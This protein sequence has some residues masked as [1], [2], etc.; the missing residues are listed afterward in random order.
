[1]RKIK[2]KILALLLLTIILI[3][4][5]LPVAYAISD[6]LINVTEENITETQENVITDNFDVLLAGI[7]KSSE[8]VLT[9]ENTQ[10]I[11]SQKQI[12]GNGLWIEEES[13]DYLIALFNSVSNKNYIINSNG[14]LVVD[15]NN[16]KN[17][18]EVE[19]K[20]NFYT[21]KFDEMIN[22]E[23]C[24]IVS[25]EETYKNLNTYDNEILD[26]IIE[27]DEYALLFTDD[28][29]EVIVLNQINY[30]SENLTDSNFELVTSIL[31]TLYH[32]DSNFVSN[33]ETY[34]LNNTNAIQ[35]EEVENMNVINS[36]NISMS[37]NVN[38]VEDNTFET[39]LSDFT[40]N[41]VESVENI[42][43]NSNEN[44]GILIDN[45]SKE[46]FLEYLNNH[47]IYTYSTNEQGY[48]VSDGIMKENQNLDF[49]DV[50]EVDLEISNILSQDIKIYIKVDNK[51]L[52]ETGE[53]TNYTFLADDEY[54]K[55]FDNSTG[56][57]RIAILNSNYF[58]ADMGYNVE[59]S[60]RFVK[61]ILDY[62]YGVEL[63]SD[64]SKYGYMI[65]ASS[66]YFGPSSSDYA[67]VG[68]VDKDE[69]VYLLGQSVGW[70]HIQYL[71]GSTEKQKS[72]Y[73]PVS[74]VTNI[75]AD[76]AVHEEILTG[77][78]RYANDKITIYS[79]DDLDIAVSVGTV[80]A[81]EGVTLI[82]KYTYSDSGKSY[83]I[84][85]V[86]YSTSSGTKRGYTYTSNLSAPD[87]PTSVAR[88]ISTASAYSGPDTSYV[89]LGGA[90]Y[91]EYVS[92][93]AKEENWV[94]VE[95]NT[96]SGRKRGFM[97]Y[98]NLEN[99]NYPSGGYNDFSENNGL[100]KA[101]S[102]LTVYGGPNSN[103][104][105]IG[106]IFNQEVVSYLGTERDLA[107]IEYSTSK[108]AKRGYVILSNLENTTAPT[109]P[110]INVPSNFTSGVYG[111]SGLG[112]NLLYYKL[113]NGSN[114]AFIVFEQHG[115][116]DAWASDG[117]ELINIA[118]RLINNL[119]NYTFADWTIYIVPYANPDGITD[120]YTNNGPGRC[121]ITT[122]ID[123]NRSWPA[124]FKPI[125]TSRNYT[126]DTAEG[127]IE[128]TN[129]KNFILNN[130]GTERN[131]LLD[132][133]GWLNKT[134]GDAE[135]GKYFC[136]TFGFTH[137]STYGS[138]YLETWGKSIGA[139]SC[140]IEFPM[141]SSSDEILTQDFSGKLT[142]G[143]VNMLQDTNT[144][145]GT[146]V[147][148]N[149]TV[150]AP[151]TLNVRSGPGTSYSKIATLNNGDEIIRIKR[152]VA[153]ANG[154]IWDKILLNDDTEGYVA[155]D[156]IAV[157]VLY[158]PGESNEDIGIIKAY[159]AMNCGMA[160]T[161]D[162]GNNI[163]EEE[164]VD[165]IKLLQT[166]LELTVT[167]VVDK[168]TVNAMGFE[169]NTTTN[170]LLQNDR[171]NHFSQA[172]YNYVNYG[173]FYGKYSSSTYKYN[174][175]NYIYSKSLDSVPID[176]GALVGITEGE[177]DYN[178]LIYTE[179]EYNE[180]IA[181]RESA[182][183][184]ASTAQA[185]G[186]RKSANNLLYFLT[187]G[188]ECWS[189]ETYGIIETTASES[190][191]YKEG[192]TSKGMYFYS[193]IEN[194]DACKELLYTSANHLMS[195]SEELVNIPTDGSPVHIQC[196]KE[197]TGST[198]ALQS[199][200]W[201]LAINN[202]RVRVSATI[203]RDY[204]GNYR[205]NMLYYV[206]DYYDYQSFEGKVIDATPFAGMQTN[207]HNL[208]KYG[209]SRNY[210][211]YADMHYTITWSTGERINSG[212]EI[213]GP[214]L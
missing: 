22:S 21:T 203:S 202:Y 41:T 211:N 121:T 85:L 113:G 110:M 10:E 49:V 33:I 67:S 35:T 20:R 102:Q 146:D 139:E 197:Y 198:G 83:N 84:S 176:E 63:L 52:S 172:K 71:V 201:Y 42:N 79:C 44:T 99:C 48:L 27:N 86:E 150:I 204:D 194:I 182:L 168:A 2:V 92:I 177:N 96:T 131:I 158:L 46:I 28:N 5:I 45:A 180:L 17:E 187:S 39:I 127:C 156:Y 148:E 167:G 36:D 94:F 130:K 8:D 123:M 111:T 60:D 53:E 6:E 77:G 186:F 191:L 134:Y 155:T 107:Y 153:T 56:T 120:G 190:E 16:I 165:G 95:Y 13:R 119:N 51:Y 69:K 136:E 161:I 147:Y 65:D 24:I 40:F 149:V 81:G 97:A 160:G 25:I 37:Q 175:I 124:Q 142:T 109:I 115:W 122:S 58:V 200:D 12:N 88:I 78:Y 208:N 32:D 183:F 112:Q 23:K 145:A 206:E 144:E 108:G 140:L 89:K 76:P 93:L 11:I 105:N 214:G 207:L 29:F 170:S 154:F 162:V 133:H 43:I 64:T 141:P 164:M 59:L 179:E 14:F 195:A 196:I 82:Y 31:E 73:V 54:V 9:F 34:S 129:L 188:G 19:E 212:A 117:I 151:E 26:M 181:D 152:G 135:I 30:N 169:V 210:T 66:V 157:D 184:Y 173:D 132:I 116:E 90:Y 137:S 163:F 106:T 166:D 98:S 185:A 192:H 143:I 138:G 199:L 57:E 126:G 50:T 114:K 3:S 18:E 1:M 213:T 104:A 128:I 205:A 47:G 118:S 125:Y 80:F 209:L 91:N 7:L 189:D 178:S 159:L 55:T 193:A 75:V 62:D 74:S 100:K 101:T 87:Y 70:Y 4:N 171:Y 68:S 61:K 103:Y 72:G 174:D 15:E 38:I